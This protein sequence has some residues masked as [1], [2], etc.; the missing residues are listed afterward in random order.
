MNGAVEN[1]DL[2]TDAERCVGG[3]IGVLYYNGSV[4]NSYSDGFVKNSRSNICIGGLIGKLNNASV[5][6]CYTMSQVDCLDSAT[7]GGLIGKSVG[8]STSNIV[9]NSYWCPEISGVET[10]AG[11]TALTLDEMKTQSSYK[12]FDFK[13]IWIMKEYPEFNW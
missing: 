11:G 5:T 7:N 8:S 13:N 4:E 6:S 1:N 12:G 2:N 10:S 9:T 3:L